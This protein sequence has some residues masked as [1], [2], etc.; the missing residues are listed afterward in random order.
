MTNSLF[1]WFFLLHCTLNFHAT[2]QGPTFSEKEEY[3]NLGWASNAG[4]K[5]LEWQKKVIKYSDSG[6]LHQNLVFLPYGGLSDSL[7]GMATSFLVSYALG[8]RFYLSKEAK[9]LLAFDSKLKLEVWDKPSSSEILR[10]I[11]TYTLDKKGTIRL[12]R[13]LHKTSS[14]VIQLQGN[15]GSVFKVASSSDFIQYDHLGLRSV[16][17]ENIFGCI[18][19]LLA[20][21]TKR[22]L[23]KFQKEIKL[24]TDS[25]RFR[26][27]LQIRTFEALR[28]KIEHEPAY[29]LKKY[30]LYIDCVKNLAR[31]YRKV[32]VYI[33]SDSN[34]LRGVLQE[35]FRK[36]GY[37]AFVTGIDMESI[38]D[39]WWQ[40][41]TSNV[42]SQDFGRISSA[43][44]AFG[45]SMLF[46]LNEAFVY[47]GKS[48][49]GRVAAASGFRE[50]AFYPIGLS[51]RRGI[52]SSSERCSSQ[53]FGMADIEHQS[54]GL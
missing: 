11:P 16:G 29:Y 7:T 52:I 32:S 26:V 23:K 36:H 13:R 8:R 45:E 24:L 3:F 5:C 25:S 22:T 48:G 21:P 17:I 4:S 43:E 44:E 39:P 27:G 33:L 28:T 2:S 38:T 14:E 34:V 18:L 30:K 31:K 9:I 1:R 51:K 6:E 15:R 41:S 50:K 54:A 46:S 42:S 10:A 19:N 20:V 47:T 37:H 40:T 12:I 35:E 49:Y 53:G